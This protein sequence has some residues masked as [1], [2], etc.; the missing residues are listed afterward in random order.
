MEIQI[1]YPKL[2]LHNAPVLR[3][4]GNG[5]FQQDDILVERID[6]ALQLD[7]VD[8]VDGNLNMLLAQRIQKRVL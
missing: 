5:I 4:H 7:A 3:D 6:L 8:E 2:H 1:Q